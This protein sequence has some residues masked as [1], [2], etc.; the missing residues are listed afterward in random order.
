MESKAAKALQKNTPIAIVKESYRREH[1]A[2]IIGRIREKGKVIRI[3]A[4]T[5]IS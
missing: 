4:H 1:I 2:A 5:L 3:S